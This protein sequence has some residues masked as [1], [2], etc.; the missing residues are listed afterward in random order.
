LCEEYTQRYGKIHK[1]EAVIE[2]CDENRPELPNVP[3]TPFAQ[4]MPDEYKNTDV[5]EAYRSYYRG[6][7]RKFAKW[8]DGSVPQWF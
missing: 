2:W 7:K 5:V 1:S 3:R 8:K 4:A 6:E